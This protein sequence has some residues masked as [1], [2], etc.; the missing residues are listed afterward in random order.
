MK[1]SSQTM[2]DMVTPIGS[3]G[4]LPDRDN[5]NALETTVLSVGSTNT[6]WGTFVGILHALIWGI[7]CI[8]ILFWG[9]D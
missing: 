6:A 8:L 1:P 4:V 9:N 3:F 7:A 5:N 2:V